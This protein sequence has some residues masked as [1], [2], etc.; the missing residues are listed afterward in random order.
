MTSHTDTQG[1]Q[2]DAILKPFDDG[3]GAA[4]TN[5]H[6]SALEL[7]SRDG[8]GLVWRCSTCHMSVTNDDWH[9]TSVV[10]EAK[11]QLTALIEL[12]SVR[13]QVKELKRAK[14]QGY[15]A[16]DL[17]KKVDRRIAS[18]EAQLTQLEGKREKS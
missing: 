1:E 15:I 5:C 8:E 6:N 9:I 3:R 7:K 10:A 12:A 2:V 17:I 4:V 14:M 11:A 16:G 13:A 18:L